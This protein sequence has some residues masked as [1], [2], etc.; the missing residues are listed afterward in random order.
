MKD[1]RTCILANSFVTK[2]RMQWFLL[3]L[4]K[5]KP[6]DRRRIIE[7]PPRYKDFFSIEMSRDQGRTTYCYEPLMSLSCNFGWKEAFTEVFTGCRRWTSQYP[8]A[9]ETT[10]RQIWRLWRQNEG[11][12]KCSNYGPISIIDPNAGILLEN[13]R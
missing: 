13:T 4:T 9:L 1:A 10:L 3:E 8:L 7:Y 5:E 11:S 6:G 2:K 12:Q